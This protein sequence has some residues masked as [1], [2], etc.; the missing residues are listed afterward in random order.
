MSPYITDTI[1]EDFP[2]PSIVSTSVT[3]DVLHH[4]F[5]VK[6]VQD[7]FLDDRDFFKMGNQI[8]FG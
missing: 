3:K 6:I 1:N 8:G 4:E 5:D 2:F 7:Q